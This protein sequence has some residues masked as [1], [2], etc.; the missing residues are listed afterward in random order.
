[1]SQRTIVEKA[2]IAVANLIANGG[3]LNNEQSNKFI[4]MV[5]ES[6]KLLGAVRT[7]RM[8]SPKR[9]I[10]KIGFADRILRPTPGSGVA[11]A[12]DQRSK[13]TTGKITLETS[14]IIAEV[15]IPYDVLEDNIERG[16]M[17]STIMQMIA[18]RAGVDLEE[19]L[20]RGDTSSSDSYLAILDGILKSI[21]SNIVNHGGASIDRSLFKNG[22]L[23]MPN[24]YM[25]NRA[26]MRH[27]LSP[28]QEIEYIDTLAD[29]ST[30]N[31]GDR[32]AE[33]RTTSSPFGVPL[34]PVALMPDAQ[35]FFTYPQNLIWGIQR[36]IQI[37]AEKDIRARVLVVVL[38]LRAAFAIEEEAACVKYTS[39]AT[40]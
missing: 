16:G 38:T 20:I 5:Q 12:A 15:H 39:I 3:Y 36:Q 7:V 24:K 21:Q 2:D 32:A 35:G 9:D 37:E 19:L 8:N 23:T 26:A 18:E 14:E 1:M 25:R 40:P 29:R 33:T 4:R 17:E 22:M 13:P 6:V 28:A 27:F 34:E 11:L 30:S 31:V 10:D